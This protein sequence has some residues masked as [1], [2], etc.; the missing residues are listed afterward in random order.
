MNPMPASTAP[1]PA[2]SPGV[3]PLGVLLAGTFMVVLDFFIVNVALP[4]LQRDLGAGAAALQWV[5]IGYGL[6]TAALLV[7]GGRLGD[8]WGRARVYRM[9]VA[10]F[11]LASAACALAPTPATL[12]A[13]RVAQGAAA[14]L[15]QP[16]VLALLGQLYPGPR[17]AGAFA[18]YGVVLGLAAALGQVLGAL[19][20]RAGGGDGSWRLCFAVNVPVG[21]ALLALSARVLP[22][23]AGAVR[24]RLDLAGAGL[25]AG[26]ATLALLPLVQGREQGW[27]AWTLLCLGLLPLAALLFVRQQRALAARGGLPLVAA[28]LMASRPLWRGLA[29]TLAFY[30]GNAAFYFVL[31]L[32]LQQSLGLDAL[33]AS[34]LFGAMAAVFFAVSMAAPALARRCGRPPIGVGALLLAAGHAAL[35]TMLLA[36]PAPPLGLLLL[37]LLL[38]GAGLGLVMAPL[39]SV[40]LGGLPPAHAGAAAGLMAS[41]QQLGNALGVA[42]VGALFFSAAPAAGF[43]RALVL[44]SLLAMLVAALHRGLSNPCKE[45][46]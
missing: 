16:Q 40:V 3:A 9:G 28:E 24:S 15:L 10:A 42:L 22:H 6:A 4:A 23:T 2:V 7:S 44:L 21:L 18:A 43:V 26:T 37:P 29:V 36:L 14:A 34:L 41:V 25:A 46:P 33:A 45:T 12:V 8:A 11:T 5:V 13:A 17:R 32:Y 30:S 1:A 27:P 31:T 19:L 38:Q 20:M 35:A 39:A